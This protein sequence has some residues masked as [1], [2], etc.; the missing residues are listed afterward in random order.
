[1]QLSKEILFVFISLQLGVAMIITVEQVV[2]AEGQ[3]MMIAKNFSAGATTAA[4]Y[5]TLK[6]LG[7]TRL[8][9]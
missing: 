3:M 6:W 4:V 7:R 1:M 2:C 5:L 9:P 8:R